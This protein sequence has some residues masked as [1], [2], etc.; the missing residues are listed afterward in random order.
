[1]QLEYKDLCG[2]GLLLKLKLFHNVNFI[3]SNQMKGLHNKIIATNLPNDRKL[4]VYILHIKFQCHKIFMLT[5][6]IFLILKS[7]FNNKTF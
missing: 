7:T 3:N 1:M 2:C 6:V 5:F 4:N